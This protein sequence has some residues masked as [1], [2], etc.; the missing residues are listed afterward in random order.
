MSLRKDIP[1]SHHEL[2]AGLESEE[3]ERHLLVAK[4]MDMRGGLP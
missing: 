1:F 3:Q 4:Q 2:V